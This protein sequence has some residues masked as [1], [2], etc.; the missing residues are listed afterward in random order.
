MFKRK[1]E[2]QISKAS[3]LKLNI[4]K[5]EIFALHH[6]LA[7]S[8]CGRNQSQYLDIAITKNK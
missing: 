6:Q 8:H 3:G 1:N 7:L 2:R 5:C 4:D